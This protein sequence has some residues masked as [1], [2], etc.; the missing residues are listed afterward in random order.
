MSHTWKRSLAYGVVLA[1]TTG[2]TTAI[3][4]QYHWA[5][6]G[7]WLMLAPLMVMRPHARD[8]WSRALHRALGTLLGVGVVHLL[9]LIAPGAIDS[10]ALAIAFSTAA[11]VAMV[12][13]WHHA[14]FVVFLTGAVVLFNSSGHGVLAMAQ[15]RLE[16]TLLGIGIALVMMGL[17]DVGFRLRQADLEATA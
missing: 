1:G 3:A 13:G 7:G 5:L 14:L 10:P 4:L 15:E 8:S 16:A 2:I 11:V 17:V 12:R 6:M 9:A